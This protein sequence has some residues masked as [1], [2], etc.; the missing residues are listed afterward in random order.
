MQKILLTGGHGMLGKTIEK[1]FS[2]NDFEV[3]VT[4]YHN[5]D[6]TDFNLFDSV[7][8]KYEVDCVIH[9]AAMT[10]VDL[11]ETEIDKAY[12]LNAVGSENVAKACEVNNVRLVAIS[13]DYIF[14]GESDRPYNE[15][16]IGGNCHSVY[17]KSKYAGEVAVKTFCRNHVIARVSWL[18]GAGGPSFVHT[19]MKLAYNDNIEQLKV[20]DDQVGNPTS[21]IA[22]A[23]KLVEIVNKHNLTGVVHLTCEGEASWFDFVTE[24]YRIKGIDKKIIPC[25]SS[26]YPT[27]AQ[28]P[29][30]SR[31]DKMV[32][33]L[34]G[35]E[36]M[37]NWRDALSE[38]LDSEK[39]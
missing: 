23:N 39:F 6:I 15:F 10:A 22:V 38:F 27:P 5:A 18:Y 32:L 2:N 7:L 30:N 24:I 4:D 19:M 35:M 21:T 1:V 28:R 33:R 11:C 9:C 34:H 26:E 17:G 29:K 14:D 36:P 16:D 37:P 13:T 3:I 31:L 8:K 25:D 20:V 12:L